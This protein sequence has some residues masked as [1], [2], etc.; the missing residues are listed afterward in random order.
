MI[1]QR[2]A[3]VRREDGHVDSH[4]LSAQDGT[5]NSTRVAESKLIH[6]DRRR[7]EA[8]RT[9]HDAQTAMAKAARGEQTTSPLDNHNVGKPTERGERTNS[10]SRIFQS[11]QQEH[12][13]R[14]EF[15]SASPR[16]FGADGLAVRCIGHTQNQYTKQ[17]GRGRNESNQR[18]RMRC[19]VHA[20]RTGRTRGRR[21]GGERATAQPSP[22]RDQRKRRETLGLG[23][24]GGGDGI[25]GRSGL[26]R[27]R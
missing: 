26:F 15:A 10:H 3:Q 5:E 11:Y 18:S 24:G 1:Q 9:K 27:T 7:S 13:G 16:E 25:G 12:A 21:E 17:T 8:A 4:N 2:G 22:G 19:A 14:F 23:R 6:A 20:F